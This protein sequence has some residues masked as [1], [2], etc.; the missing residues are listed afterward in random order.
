MYVVID[1]SLMTCEHNKAL[2]VL[3]PCKDCQ[4]ST[5]AWARD[6][7]HKIAERQPSA[8]VVWAED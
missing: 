4:D 3:G 2:N 7:A 8:P 6:T 5:E 1:E